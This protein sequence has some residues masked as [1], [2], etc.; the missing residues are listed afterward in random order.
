[1]VVIRKRT[2]AKQTLRAPQGTA[3]PPPQWGRL[4]QTKRSL[5]Q[6]LIWRGHRERT[7][8]SLLQRPRGGGGVHWGR[9]NTPPVTPTP[10]S[11]SLLAMQRAHLTLVQR[12]RV[13]RHLW[14]KLG[15]L[16]IN[17]ISIDIKELPANFFLDVI[18]VLQLY[19]FKI[20]IF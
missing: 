3:R 14:E 20:L 12:S 7:A 17:W 10:P 1:M 11:M 15:N 18:V 5:G 6:P 19:N 13:L 4:P 2:K 8:G 9:N 16:N